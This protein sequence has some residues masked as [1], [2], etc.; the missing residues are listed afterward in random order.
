M[1]SCTVARVVASSPRLGIGQAMVSLQAVRGKAATSTHSDAVFRRYRQARMTRLLPT[2]LLAAC[3]LGSSSTRGIP[4]SVSGTAPTCPRWTSPRPLL[5]SG[6]ETV[7]VEAPQ[8][9]RT[10]R[11]LLLLGTPTILIRGLQD[12]VGAVDATQVG[13]RLREHGPADL[14]ARPRSG[15]PI[16]FPRTVATGDGAVHI[17]WGR[18]TDPT[19]VMPTV[20]GILYARYDGAAWTDPRVLATSRQ[21]F[22]EPGSQAGLSS[23]GTGVVLAVPEVDSVGGKYVLVARASADRSSA[24]RIPVSAFAVYATSAAPTPSGVV[25]AYV[26]S[27]GPGDRNSLFVTKSA[28]TGVTWSPPVRV[29]AG[30]G[31]GVHHPALLSNGSRLLLTWQL[32]SPDGRADSIAV[33]ASG[34]EGASWSRVVSL[35]VSGGV[36]RLQA[37]LSD[38]ALNVA[39][40]VGDGSVAHFVVTESGE[41]VRCPLPTTGRVISYAL[42]PGA[43]GVFVWAS[44]RGPVEGGGPHPYLLVSHRR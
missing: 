16:L 43:G 5:L 9:L 21:F 34:D 35:P 1:W 10:E 32:A 27:A 29:Q 31:D 39:A 7:Y 36:D 8:V 40:L 6:G 11:G 30:L 42:F 3:M 23:A 4:P 19:S 24:A 2:V 33:A 22:W 28:D 20:Q 38:G 17:T 37:T 14:V 25:V 41:S 26:A 13:V 18:S 15:G 44:L 12:S